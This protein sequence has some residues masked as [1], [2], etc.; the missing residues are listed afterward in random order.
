MTLVECKNQDDLRRSDGLTRRQKVILA[1]KIK[2]SQVGVLR[3]FFLLDQNEV[4]TGLLCSTLLFPPFACLAFRASCPRLALAR[5][6]RVR[7]VR[8]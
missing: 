7:C 5:H 8:Y 1:F 6:K 3:D 2:L 4:V